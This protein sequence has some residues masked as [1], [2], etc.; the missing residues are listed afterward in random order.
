MAKCHKTLRW[1]GD[2]GPTSFQCSHFVTFNLV[3]VLLHTCVGPMLA[4]RMANI[5]SLTNLH[6]KTRWHAYVGPMLGKRVTFNMKHN[7]IMFF[8][9]SIR[10]LL[11]QR[12]INV[13]LSTNFIQN[14]SGRHTLAQCWPNVMRPTQLGHVKQVTG[15]A[16]RWVNVV[17]STNFWVNVVFS[18][19][20]YPKPKWQAYLG[21]ML[22]QR[23]APN[24]TRSC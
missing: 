5:V 2:I 13:V 21:P 18:T 9:T 1:V 3:L 17:F 23:N 10:C 4:Q 16:R 19:N 12:W 8:K 6:P 24:A 22:A 20:F 14:Q 11:A 7:Q 15:V